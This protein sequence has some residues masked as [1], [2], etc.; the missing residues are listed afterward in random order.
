MATRPWVTGHHPAGFT[1][2]WQQPLAGLSALPMVRADVRQLLPRRDP[3]STGP[4]EWVEDL[5]LVVDE[6]SSNGLRHGTAPVHAAL[7]TDGAD[8]L[9]CV[10]DSA[11]HSGPVPA[12]GRAPGAGG[13]GL[14]LVA[15]LTSACGWHTEDDHKTVW[16]R[17]SP[18]SAGTSD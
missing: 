6:I 10:T 7:W 18:S 15:D 5:I 17:L 2:V 3:D 12:E 8:W 16:A 9:I 4:P 1:L 14:Y 13:H 11:A